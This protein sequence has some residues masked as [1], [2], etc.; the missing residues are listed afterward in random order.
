[1][2][3]NTPP[4]RLSEFETQALSRVVHV[5]GLRPVAEVVRTNPRALL[6][7]GV[8]AQALDNVYPVGLN[9]QDASTVLGTAFDN[10]DGENTGCTV[11]NRATRR[12]NLFLLRI[13]PF[14][15]DQ[16]VR[17]TESRYSA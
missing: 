16:D 14:H 1:M 6:H 9:D 12:G 7:T 3:A 5:P 10:A 4:A 2:P 17:S 8:V 11:L 13:I 15:P